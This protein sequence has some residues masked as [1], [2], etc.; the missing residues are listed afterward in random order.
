MNEKNN[1]SFNVSYKPIDQ[2]IDLLSETFLYKNNNPLKHNFISYEQWSYKVMKLHFPCF[3]KR[4]FKKPIQEFT[5]EAS[6]YTFK[7]DE[8][9]DFTNTRYLYDTDSMLDTYITAGR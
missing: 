5:A 3:I 9:N 4:H 2:D 6:Y 8:G 1:L 7:S